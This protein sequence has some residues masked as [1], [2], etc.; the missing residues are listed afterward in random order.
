MCGRTACTVRRAG[1]GN[2]T[3]P[4]HRASPRPNYPRLA[5]TFS[6]APVTLGA[7]PD[8]RG[9]NVEGRGVVPTAGQRDL[10]FDRAYGAHAP[11]ILRFALRRVDAPEAAEDVVAEAFLAAWR[12]WER[13]P[14]APDEVLPWLYR[15]AG[16]AV[17]NQRR[18]DRRQVRLSVRLAQL[19]ARAGG[20]A[21]PSEPL[22]DVAALIDAFGGMSKVDQ[23]VLRLLAWEQVTGARELGLAL[24]ISPAA[25]RVRIFRARQRLR[26]RVAGTD[27]DR[28][29][30]D[31]SSSGACSRPGGKTSTAV[32]V[33]A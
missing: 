21:D 2:G 23:D 30:D 7:V 27:L 31:N 5:L 1:A 14:Q 25:A 8:L 19:T 13:V 15:F 6:L 28:R 20:D 18:S 32:N 29:R 10:S 24:G 26:A 16:S 9:Q 22:L 3:R 12:Q 11:S 17:C 4:R 33:E